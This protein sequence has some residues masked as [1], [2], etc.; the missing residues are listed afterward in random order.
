[1]ST[2]SLSPLLTTAALSA[3][4]D[5]AQFTE[6]VAAWAEGDRAEMGDDDFLDWMEEKSSI[7]FPD[8]DQ[9]MRWRM[10]HDMA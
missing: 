1:M 7:F 8:F 4:A 9:W 3:I 5:Q 6:A 2:L 10:D